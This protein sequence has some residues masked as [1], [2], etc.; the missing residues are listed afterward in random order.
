LDGFND[1]LFSIDSIKRRPRFLVKTVINEMQKSVSKQN[2]K[3]RDIISKIIYL[4]KLMLVYRLLHHGDIINESNLNIDGR[5]FELTS[6]Q[7]FLFDS[8]MASKEKKALPEVLAALSKFLR[9]KGELQKKTLEGVV[10]EALN[11]L[12]K[13]ETRTTEPRIISDLDGQTKTFYTIAHERIIHS[14]TFA[15]NG[16]A[17]TIPN[18]KAFYS[19]EYEKVTHKHVLSICKNRFLGEPDSIGRGNEKA[20]ALT[21]DKDTVDRVGKTFEVVDQIEKLEEPQKDDSDPDTEDDGMIWKDYTLYSLY[22]PISV[23]S[24]PSL[25]I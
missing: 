2:P 10:Y 16:E 1:R 6:P 24:S 18:E 9:K 21:F 17:S 4:R 25:A 20:R 13:E 12:F 22:R 23:L 3:Y 7:I 19:T 11:Q 15:A 14:I 8:E 5:A